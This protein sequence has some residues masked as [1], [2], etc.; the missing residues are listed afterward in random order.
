MKNLLLIGLAVIAIVVVARLSFYTVDA[1][2]Y[3]Y[4]TVL[5]EH[6]ETY[7]GGD[8]ENGAGLKFGL[9]WPIVQTQ[10]LDRRLQQFDL[11]SLDQLTHDPKSKTVDKILNLEAYVVWKITDKEG[12]DR[13][14]KRIGTAS[15]ARE[16]LAP[17]ITGKLGAAV[18]KKRMEDFTIDPV[19][20]ANRVDQT[21][22]SLRREL[23][24]GLKD[25]CRNE[26]G[27]DL[28]D[29]RLRRFNHPGSVRDSI[30]ARIRSERIKE[31][32]RY[33][34]EGDFQAKN[35]LS[36]ADETVNKLIAKAKT[37]E[38]KIRSDADIEARNIRNKAYAQEKEFYNFLLAMDSL[39]AIVGGEKTF[40][41]LSTHRPMFR[42]MFDEPRSLDKNK[43]P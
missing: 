19:T 41:L 16:I 36:E 24:D 15:R 1:A 23:L 11:P 38:A 21:V 42:L 20:G 7:D 34:D 6:R 40:L 39:Q 8:A 26:Y 30:F 17:E 4:V 31:A 12:V 43:K 18:G 35:K 9:P 14:V 25:R 37:E 27:I 2:E 10:R 22:E 3:V 29:I 5:G 32:K 33:E 28:V 13:F